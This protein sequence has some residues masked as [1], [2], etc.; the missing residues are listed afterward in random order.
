MRLQQ[1][2]GTAFVDRSLIKGLS[3][4]NDNIQTQFVLPA[5]ISD[6]TARVEQT[7]KG[8]G[9]EEVQVHA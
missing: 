8:Q 3:T 6:I 9:A 1:K 2:V 5:D 4:V 7:M